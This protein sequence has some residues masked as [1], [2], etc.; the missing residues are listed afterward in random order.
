V[1]PG[2]GEG[3]TGGA[4]VVEVRSSNGERLVIPVTVAR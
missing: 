2:D 4:Y 3:L 1:G